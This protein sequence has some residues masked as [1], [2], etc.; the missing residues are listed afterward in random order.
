[1]R[2]KSTDIVA[3]LVRAF[4]LIELL[5]VI[6]IIAIL[7]GMLLPALAAAREKARRTACIENLDQMGKALASYTSDYADYLPSWPGD[8]KRLPYVKNVLDGTYVA[9][10]WPETANYNFA[11]RGLY[12]DP[13]LSGAQAVV[14]TNS[15]RANASLANTNVYYSSVTT[16]LG[17]YN[18]RCIAF[19]GKITGYAW[20]AG[21]TTE[22]KAGP[23]GLG[24]LAVTGYLGDPKAYFCPSASNMPPDFAK[25]GSP[26]ADWVVAD[27]TRFKKL[28]AIDPYSMLHGDYAGAQSGS[29]IAG[30]AIA[31][32]DCNYNYRGIPLAGSLF[33]NY[34][35]TDMA[36]PGTMP[37]RDVTLGCAPFKT[38]K[39]LGSR[40]LVSDS[41]SQAKNFTGTMTDP[42]YMG[43][44]QWAHRDGYNVLYG[45]Y[46][47][48][49]YGDPQQRLT[50]QKTSTGTWLDG[51]GSL[52]AHMSS[53]AVFAAPTSSSYLCKPRD[54]TGLM[55][56]HLF[57][58]KGGV[59]GTTNDFAM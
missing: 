34:L 15:Y 51:F 44:G 32:I 53:M 1:M 7:A 9:T 29:W 11:D 26:T 38:M 20:P 54:S 25:D 22:L 33:H 47:T 23:I 42:D 58:V 16:L 59:D 12:T 24:Y 4:T 41:F 49:W 31:R 50:Y 13:K 6:A 39:Q 45:D 48:S 17:T 52:N 10:G 37:V 57:D 56:W 8:G 36:L 43:K 40:A 5:V 27:L 30:N 35:T 14:A 46:H 55:I 21:D 28:G 3:M 18:Y 2:R 19:G